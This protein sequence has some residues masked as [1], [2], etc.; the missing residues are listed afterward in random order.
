MERDFDEIQDVIVENVRHISGAKKSRAKV[1][2]VGSGKGGVGKTFVSTS[3]A[4]SLSKLGHNVVVVDL[5]LSGANVH[6]ALGLNP[7]HMNIR[8]FFES[9]KAL[10]ELVIPTPF[11]KLSYIQGYWDSWVPTDFAPNQIQKLIPE[12][13]TLRAD[14]VIVDIGAGAM[15]GHLD[16]FKAADEKIIVSSPEPSSIEKTYRYLEAYVCNTLREDAAPE[17]WD[18]LLSTLRHHRQGSLGRPF[19]FKTYLTSQSGIEYSFFESLSKNPIRLIVNGCRN[20]EN[21]ELGYSMKSVCNKYYDLSIDFAGAID[22]DNAVWQAAR[23][24]EPMLISQPFTPLAGQFL[25]ICKHLIDP[26]E[27]RA[28]I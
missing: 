2:V 15:A 9:Q 21:T 6:T 24:R 16:L 7:S 4:I 1:W 11:S 5:D 19:S 10:Q 28:V 25:N 20:H 27:L 23:V 13:H 26:E 3:L 17:A 22:F 14:Y 8:H 12:L 18:K